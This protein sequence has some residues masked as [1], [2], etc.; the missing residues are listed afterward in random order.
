MNISE[1]SDF[2]H[3]KRCIFQSNIMILT[4]LHLL[5]AFDIILGISSQHKSAIGSV[6]K[7]LDKISHLL[8]KTLQIEEPFSKSAT[9]TVTGVTGVLTRQN[10][11]NVCNKYFKN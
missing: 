1:N 3:L 7:N 4:Q 5:F 2:L 11:I 9:V 10:H 6:K 8:E